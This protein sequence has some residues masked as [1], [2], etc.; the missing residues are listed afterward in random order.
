M[1]TIIYVEDENS[2]E[3]KLDLMAKYNLAGLAAWRRNF[4]TE[5]VWK[6]IEQTIK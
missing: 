5:E 2:L 4:E 6:V 3:K 1:K